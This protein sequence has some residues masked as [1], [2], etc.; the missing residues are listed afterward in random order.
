M[1]HHL[2]NL[3]TLLRFPL[4]AIFLY[5]FAWQSTVEWR[6]IATGCFYLSALT[7]LLDGVLARRMGAITRIGA[8]LDPL[9][10]KT[11][12]LAGFFA[13]ILRRDMEWE[14]WKTVVVAAV[15]VIALRELVI[16]I[17][18]AYKA[19]HHR[20]IVTS[21]VAKA[22]TTTELITLIVAFAVLA[23]IDLFGW[24]HPFLIH[25]I[26]LGIIASAVLAVLSAVDYLK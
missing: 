19:Y 21:F 22:K 16:T 23:A 1:R 20:P 17:V 2:P 18:R 4:T 26:G 10:D 15:L 12:V 9:A 8:F 11:Q 24:G 7:D 6:L 3:I 13:L 25:L 14:G 5:G